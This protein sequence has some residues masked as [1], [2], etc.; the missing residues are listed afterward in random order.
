[1]PQ[2]PVV[3]AK[4]V[5][6]TDFLGPYLSMSTT[7]QD[8][9]TDQRQTLARLYDSDP[10][11]DYNSKEAAGEI[12]QEAS[13]RAA[14]LRLPELMQVWPDRAEVPD[15]DRYLVECLRAIEKPPAYLTYDELAKVLNIS[16]R[17][18]R[19]RIY[20]GSLPEPMSV[21]RLKRFSVK[22]LREHGIDL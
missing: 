10:A 13:R 6:S 18:V 11:R 14:E 2:N 9:L 19:R 20:Q 7:F 8:W 4:F 5:V 3:P 22:E 16:I 17:S 12:A 1:M 15:V 21:G